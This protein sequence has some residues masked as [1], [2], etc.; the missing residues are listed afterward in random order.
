MEGMQNRYEA[1]RASDRASVVGEAPSDHSL[2]QGLHMELLSLT[3]NARANLGSV[4]SQRGRLLCDLP[5][6]PGTQTPENDPKSTAPVSFED[7]HRAIGTLRNVLL[8]TNEHLMAMR[9]IG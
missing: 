1:S 9:K 7:L 8:S 4:V 5:P 3:S 2:M 6:E